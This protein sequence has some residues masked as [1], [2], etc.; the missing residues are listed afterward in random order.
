MTSRWITKATIA[1]SA[2][3]MTVSPIALQS[4]AAQTYDQGGGY[5]Q[6]DQGYNRG[7]DQG[8]YNNQGGYDQRDDQ[9]GYDR[10]APSSDDEYY[11]DNGQPPGPPPDYDGS[12]PPP[13]PSGYQRPSD[14]RQQS[15]EDERYAED[16]ERWADENCVKS[17]GDVAAGAVIGGL[18]GALLGSAIGGPGHHAGGAVIGAAIGGTSGAAIASSSGGNETSPGCPPGYVARDGAPAFYYA[19][20]AGPY[21]YAAPGWYRPWVWYDDRW[22]FRPYP[23]HVW[24]YRH[25]SH[26]DHDRGGHWDHD[27]WRR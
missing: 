11:D 22:E 7:D 18:F 21:Y 5:D 9:G 19:G 4:A 2:L 24:Y 10:S 8:G 17:H 1:V 3:C 27:H 14:Y 15:A 6:R 25:Y 13:P 20:Y 26:W 16:A 12:E 23:Y